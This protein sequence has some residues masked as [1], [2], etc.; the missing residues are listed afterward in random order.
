MSMDLLPSLAFTALLEM[1]EDWRADDQAHQ[2]EAQNRLVADFENHLRVYAGTSRAQESFWDYA[3]RWIKI[4][5]RP[6]E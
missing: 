2:R 5:Y 3:R 1:S 4:Y 6:D